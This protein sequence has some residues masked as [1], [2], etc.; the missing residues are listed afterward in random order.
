MTEI[1]LGIVEHQEKLKECVCKYGKKIQLEN[2][3]QHN[4]KLKKDLSIM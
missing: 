4:T 3:I 1:F 2:S